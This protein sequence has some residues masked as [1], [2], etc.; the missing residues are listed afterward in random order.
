MTLGA[1]VMG[2]GVRSADDGGATPPG[3]LPLDPDHPDVAAVL[4]EGDVEDEYEVEREPIA[5]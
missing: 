5:R 4:D 2:S 3:L 1:P